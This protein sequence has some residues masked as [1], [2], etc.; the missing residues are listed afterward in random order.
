MNLFITGFYYFSISFLVVFLFWTF[1]T[2]IDTRRR[3]R[4]TRMLKGSVK[5]LESL[6]KLMKMPKKSIVLEGDT[7]EKSMFLLRKAFDK[8]KDG[9]INNN[10]IKAVYNIDDKEKLGKEIDKNK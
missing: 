3:Y 10:D 2:F 4:T 7:S 1:K 6:K 8:I 5:D 9:M